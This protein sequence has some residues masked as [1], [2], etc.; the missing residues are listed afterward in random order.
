M[1]DVFN[2]LPNLNM[3]ELTRAFSVKANDMMLVIYV[4]ALIRSVLALHNLIGA[5]QGTATR[6]PWLA[7]Q[8]NPTNLIEITDL[9]ATCLRISMRQ[10]SVWRFSL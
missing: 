4:S 5:P 7:V 9:D 2:L 8:L 6:G 3:E 1:Q 10:I